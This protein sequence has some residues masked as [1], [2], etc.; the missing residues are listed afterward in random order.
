MVGSLRVNPNNTLIIASVQQF[1][2]FQSIQ[3]KNLYIQ[4]AIFGG[5][6]KGAIDIRS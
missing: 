2:H 6:S 3:S 1:I 4:V 5:S